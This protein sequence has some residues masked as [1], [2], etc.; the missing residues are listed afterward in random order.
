MLYTFLRYT[1]TPLARIL[2]RV[3]ILG[4]DNLPKNQPYILASNHNDNSDPVF[5]SMLTRKK[6][7]FM[8][9]HNLL[10]PP[11]KIR[12]IIKNIKKYLVFVEM[13][14][15]KSQQAIDEACKLLK[16]GNMFSIFPEGTTRGKERIL[17]AHRGVARIALKA[18][19]PVVPIAIIGSTHMYERGNELL[20]RKLPKVVINIGSPLYFEKY[21]GKHND[22]RITK[23]IANQVM[24]EI[25]RL[26]YQ[27]H[28]DKK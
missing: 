24:A 19:V 10:L 14:T 12:I 16:K 9:K 11:N 13:G 27:C 5:L 3:K 2:L 22:R 4:K 17:P 8:A 6:I 7:C 28:K 21:Y 26:Y 18:K 15:G 25:R 20:P 1:I 23:K